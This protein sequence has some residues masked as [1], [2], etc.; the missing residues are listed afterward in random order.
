MSFWLELMYVRQIRPSVVLFDTHSNRQVVSGAVVD[1]VRFTTSNG[2]TAGQVESPNARY[3]TSN[4]ILALAGRSDRLLVSL[5]EPF[6]Q[7]SPT[8][9]RVE[10][11]SV[12][13]QYDARQVSVQESALGTPDSV[14]TIDNR[15]GTTSQEVP[16]TVS[17]SSTDC[18][19]ATLSQPTFMYVVD[20]AVSTTS[21]NLNA[22][23]GDSLQTFE[24]G[25]QLATSL[26]SSSVEVCQDVTNEVSQLVRAD[27]GELVT[28]S[29]NS[30]QATYVLPWTAV[31]NVFFTSNPKIATEQ[32][33]SGVLQG[34]RALGLYT[35]FTL[36]RAPTAAPGVGP[37]PSEPAETAETC[38]TFRQTLVLTEP[39]SAE[40]TII[41]ELELVNFTSTF[42]L[43]SSQVVVTVDILGTEN[44][45]LE[46]GN[47]S[48]S[49]AYKV[50]FSS[51]TE[52][53][54]SFPG[55]FLQNMANPVNRRA[56][57]ENLTGQGIM[58]LPGTTTN[59]Q[60]QDSPG[61]TADSKSSSASII[62]G[63][64]VGVVVVCLAVMAFAWYRKRTREGKTLTSEEQA[65]TNN[66]DLE[67]VIAVA[68]VLDA[69]AAD[70]PTDAH[71]GGEL[72]YKAQGQTHAAEDTRVQRVES[73]GLADED[74]D[75]KMQGQT[76][77]FERTVNSESATATDATI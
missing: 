38:A 63:V 36:E 56:L 42:I 58:I 50:C 74:L 19:T 15:E 10:V 77:A 28:A 23:I 61:V 55:L 1:A 20:V 4:P 66:G 24:V 46:D 11:T 70:N 34:N 71:T 12:D 17:Q 9:Y 44:V 64:V 31:A 45:V 68:A 6:Y 16:L 41:F 49:V 32:T 21:T 60:L 67:P 51:M 76:V 33:L 73:G 2:R 14:V 13:Y 18:E 47:V 39:L 69:T 37:S 30:R 27:P 3:R 54:S 40:T 8:I 35:E 57:E 53:V 52:D 26:E 48:L 62:I 43:N 59:A 65:T 25:A 7:T 72:P 22:S 29:A 5:D 75:Y